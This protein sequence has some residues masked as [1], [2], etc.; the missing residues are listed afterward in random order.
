MNGLNPIVMPDDPAPSISIG[1]AAPQIVVVDGQIR[2]QVLACGAQWLVVDK[3]CGMSIH[4][5]PGADLCSLT[6]NAVR[7]GSLPVVGHDLSAIHAVHRIDRDT[8]GVVMLAGD[9]ETAAFFSGQFVAKS[10][11]K[12]YLAVVH[13]R[14]EGSSTDPGGFD[15]NWPLTVTAAGRNDPM[16][17]GKRM[18]CATRWRSLAHSRHYSLVA[19]EPLTGRKHQ[20]RRHAKL[21]GHPVVGDR[22]YG[23]KRSLA[24][25]RRHCDFNRLGLHAHV[26]TL[27]LPGDAKTTTFRSGGLPEAMRQLLESDR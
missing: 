2:I 16:G 3:P 8:S 5:D 25:L 1:G 19:C 7:A 26:L 13:G 21:A 6:L 20:I 27:R 10:V 12:Q 4:N 15:W 11:R 18:P 9:P 24:Y 23:S 22:R 17:K 14:L